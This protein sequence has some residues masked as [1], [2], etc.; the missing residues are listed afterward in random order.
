MPVA[1]RTC[2][3]KKDTYYFEPLKSQTINPTLESPIQ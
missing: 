3:I 1:S 2:E